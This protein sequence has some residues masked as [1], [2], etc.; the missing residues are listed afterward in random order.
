MQLDPAASAAGARLV[1]LGAVGSTNTEGLARAR[2]GERGALWMTAASQ[3]EGRGRRGRSWVS[4]PGNLY[5]SLLLSEPSH[6]ARFAELSFVAGLALHDAIA[7]RIPGLAARLSLKWPN[8]LLID[9]CKVAGILIEGEG[10]AVVIGIGVNCLSHPP[11]T[12]FPATDLAAAGVRASAETV[13]GA[14]TGAMTARLAQWDRGTGFAAIR[15]EWLARAA[16]LGK[17]IRLTLPD[18]QVAG[19]LE[20]IDESGRLVLR[21]P[22]GTMQAVAAGDVV[23]AA[24]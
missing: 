4:E 24:R 12:D 9:R 19:V 15:S 3:S 7:G 5:A 21:L 18:R 20:T 14:L 10:A 16:Y 1:T 13:F 8:D 23:M 2:A 22:D 6:P 11:G 17:P